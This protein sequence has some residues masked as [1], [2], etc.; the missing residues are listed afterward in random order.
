MG[1][2]KKKGSIDLGRHTMKKMESF[3]LD[4]LTGRLLNEMAEES[5]YSKTRLIE[6]AVY[7][8]WRELCQEEKDK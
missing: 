6:L 4:Q 2:F 3:R 8:L 1:T 5:G 7:W